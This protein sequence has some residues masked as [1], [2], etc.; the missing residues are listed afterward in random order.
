MIKIDEDKITIDIIPKVISQFAQNML[1]AIGWLLCGCL[2]I[3]FL[4]L[5]SFGLFCL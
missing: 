5:T 1:L 2:N 3:P 4:I